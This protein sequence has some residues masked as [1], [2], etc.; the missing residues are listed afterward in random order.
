MPKI[1]STAQSRAQ[2]STWTSGVGEVSRLAISASITSPCVAYAMSRTGT[3]RSTMPATSR[4]RANAATTGNAPNAFST[5]GGP[6]STQALDM[7]D[8]PGHCRWHH[9]EPRRYT[10]QATD[11]RIPTE[12]RWSAPANDND[13]LRPASPPSSA[14]S[15]SPYPAAWS[16]A[17]PLVAKRAADARPTRRCSMGPT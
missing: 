8:L 16:R 6:N 3:A 13:E 12:R 4:R 5:L 14:R 9:R 17:P 7:A 10:L 1:S 15:A 2:S 11:T